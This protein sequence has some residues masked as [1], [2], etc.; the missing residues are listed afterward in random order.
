MLKFRAP[1][2]HLRLTALLARAWPHV[3]QRQITTTLRQRGIKV[4]GRHVQDANM[5]IP[6]GSLIT[7]TAQPGEVSQTRTPP[8]LVESTEN[9]AAFRIPLNLETFTF[10]EEE[11]QELLEPHSLDLATA[12]YSTLQ[13]STGAAGLILVSKSESTATYRAIVPH[14]PYSNGVLQADGTKKSTAVHFRVLSNR[15]QLTEVELQCTASGYESIRTQLAR[16]GYPVLGDAQHGGIM[17][18]GGLRLWLYQAESSSVNLTLDPPDSFWPNEPVFMVDGQ[19]SFQVSNATQRIL[20]QGH[21]WI[22][23][24]DDTSDTGRFPIGSQVQVLCGD[25]P[26]GYAHIEGPNKL[27]ARLWSTK[28][29]LPQPS[30][31]ERVSNAIEKRKPLFESSN[32]DKPTDAFRLIHGE[33]DGFGGLFIDRLGPVL[34]VLVA[35]GA[36]LGFKDRAINE[37]RQQLGEVLGHEPTVIEVM[38][39]RPRPQGDVQCVQH[40]AGPLSDDVASDRLLVQENGLSYR[41]RT[42][43]TTPNKAVPGVG[44]FMDQ[45]VNRERLVRLCPGRPRWLNLFCHTG[46]FSVALLHAGVEHITSVDLS[47]PYLHWLNDNLA[48]NGLTD[49]DHVT[50][51][52]D[53]RR[54]LERLNAEERFDGII[55]DPPTAAASGRRFWSVKRDVGAL[56]EA[57]LARLSPGGVLLVT[58]N[59]RRARGSLD[60]ILRDAANSQGIA[61]K[62]IKSAG[63]SPDFPSMPGFPEGD[64]VTGSLL[65][66]S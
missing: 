44:L 6:P 34:R 48:L 15:D 13:P 25:T 58:R 26:L 42:G 27:V 61:I 40:T 30:V 59:D 66:R 29:E 43:L 39:L 12:N 49:R 33:A 1:G 46:A 24:D 21:P 45:R 53:A 2:E 38:H 11:I 18:D 16:A 35:G 52:S 5:R 7:V 32:G 28:T 50:R 36:C 51:K 56:I 64:A 3:S 55:L 37:L 22:L 14:L 47:A 17:V 54:F 8:V 65:I 60:P 9:H 20:K 63:P 4:G 62:S 41:V 31:E 19:E 10:T 57:V 23:K